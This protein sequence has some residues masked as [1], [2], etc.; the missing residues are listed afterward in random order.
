[1]RSIGGLLKNR[2]LAPGSADVPSALRPNARPLAK[3]G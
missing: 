2:R 3:K 1:M